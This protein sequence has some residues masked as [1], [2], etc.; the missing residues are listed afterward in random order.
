MRV[1]KVG[2]LPT[3]VPPK[4][5]D[6]FARQIFGPSVGA[7]NLSV[8]YSVMLANGG[9]EMHV[10]PGAEHVFYVL[11]GE[12]KVRNDKDTFIVHAGEGLVIEPGEAHQVT[13][14]GQMD[15]E[16]ITMTSPPLNPK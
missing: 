13:G 12:L 7:H 2:S 5:Y 6:V 15:C 14:T 9:A 10:H 1:V 4:H 8:G 3:A 16:Y 11:R